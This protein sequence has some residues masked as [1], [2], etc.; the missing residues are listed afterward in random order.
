MLGRDDMRSNLLVAFAALLCAGIWPLQADAQVISGSLTGYTVGTFIPDGTLRSPAGV[1]VDKSGNIYVMDS[2]NFV[3]RKYTSTGTGQ[4]LAGIAGTNQKYVKQVVPVA[5]RVAGQC[6]TETGVHCQATQ[7]ILSSPRDVA[8]DKAG[9]VYISDI[10]AGKIKKIDIKTGVITN[11]AGGV[12]GG[13]SPVQLHAPSGMAIDAKGNLY[14]AD[15]VNNAVRKITPPV[16]PAKLGTIVT[17]AGLGP[18][19]P[20]CAAEGSVAATSMLTRPQDVAV[21]PSGNVYIADTGCRKIRKIATDGTMST[22]AGTGVDHTGTP[23]EVP[24]TA[25]SGVATAVNLANPIGIA[26]DKAG[27]LLIADPGFD[28]VWFYN[29]KAGSIQV[30]AGLAPQASVCTTSTNPQGDG[31]YGNAAFLNVPGK[32]AVDSAGNIY[33]P[34]QGGTK[35]PTHPFDVRVLRPTGQ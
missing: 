1:E 19:Q 31:C 17:I 14:V 18:D 24:F 22:V 33:I 7:A 6:Y 21:D 12:D 27:N 11:Y 23:L 16:A 13:W 29:A 10:S 15:K 20:G 28:L 30:L 9:N 4:V 26:L 32:P 5:N 2:G 35:S 8:I 3:V 25:S 34:E